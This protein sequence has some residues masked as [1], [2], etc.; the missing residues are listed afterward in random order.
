MSDP[1][2]MAP[3]LTES[4]IVRVP[5]GKDFPL[6]VIPPTN[7]TIVVAARNDTMAQHLGTLFERPLTIPWD[8]TECVPED[9]L[10]QRLPSNLRARYNLP[11]V[12]APEQVKGWHRYQ[13]I[14][15]AAYQRDQGAPRITTAI[16]HQ[17]APV[18]FAA[19]P[20]YATRQKII[21]S[22]TGTPRIGQL[23]AA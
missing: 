5:L 21:R 13:R 20:L 22:V 8:W 4:L 12:F 15:H 16:E 17:G 11:W 7:P 3:D 6:G 14:S 18:Y 9:Y 19:R 1:L 2:L 23:L 10:H